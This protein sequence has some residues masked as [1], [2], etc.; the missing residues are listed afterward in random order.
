MAFKAFIKPFQAPQRSVK[1]K[2]YVNFCSSPGSG[3]EKVNETIK[4]LHLSATI[5]QRSFVTIS[6]QIQKTVEHRGNLLN[7]TEILFKSYSF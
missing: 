2:I 4:I 6:T 1:I 5:Y 7:L 3:A